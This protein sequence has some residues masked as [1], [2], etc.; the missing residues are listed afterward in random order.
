MFV[1]APDL[2]PG[3]LVRKPPRDGV[4]CRCDGRRLEGVRFER[5]KDGPDW[6]SRGA[7]RSGGD[8]GGGGLRRWDLKILD[9]ARA[10]GEG[11]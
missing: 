9:K 1:E 6:L 5:I 11:D 2:P 7:G 3:T 10:A 8:G 4:Q